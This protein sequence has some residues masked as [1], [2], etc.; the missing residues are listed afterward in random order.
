MAPDTGTAGS[1]AAC[2]IDAAYEFDAPRF[3]DFVNEETEEA[4]R[5][6]ES[7]F[8][9]SVSHAP[10]R[11]HSSRIAPRSLSSSVPDS[12]PHLEISLTFFF[13]RFP[14]R[15]VRS[16]GPGVEGGGE[17]HLRLRLRRR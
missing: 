17:G 9:V 15:S 8:E 12:P 2:Q 3:F 10:S 16:E 13:S 14:A 1:V 5:S 11:K 7:W 6:A 4:I